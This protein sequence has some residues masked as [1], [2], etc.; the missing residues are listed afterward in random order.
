MQLSVCACS[1][2]AQYPNCAVLRADIVLVELC[3]DRTGLLVDPDAP[4]PPTWYTP[5]FSLTGLPTAPGWPTAVQLM[6]LLKGT[7]CT[8]VSAADIEDN[9]V[10]LL[11]TGERAGSPGGQD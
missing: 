6:G 11:S 5:R 4:P 3:K 7:G 1:P 8:P 2:L 9:A 10:A